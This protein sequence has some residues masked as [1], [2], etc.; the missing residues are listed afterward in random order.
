MMRPVLVALALAF[1]L[2][3]S[4]AAC[5]KPDPAPAQDGARDAGRSTDILGKGALAEPQGMVQQGKSAIVAQQCALACGAK[6]GIDSTPCT[7][8]CIAECAS[9]SDLV[10]IDACASKTA[11][12]SPQ[13]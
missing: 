9:A 12:S 3:L 6:P 7:H 8:R 2:S 1:A 5:T 13:L 11:E 4:L 10:A